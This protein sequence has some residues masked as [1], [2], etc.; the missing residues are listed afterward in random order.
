MVAQKSVVGSPYRI[1]V[2]TR[3]IEG[4]ALAPLQRIGCSRYE[5]QPFDDEALR[6]FAENWFVD[7]A[8]RADRFV[9]QIREA[10]LDELVQVPLLATIAAII[11]QQH[12]DRPLPGN[13]YQLY[14][15]YLAFLLPAR[16][17]VSG[18]FEERR[19][20]LLEHLGRVRLETDTSLVGL[21]WVVDLLCDDFVVTPEEMQVVRP[22]VEAF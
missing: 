17:S 3:P 11:F 16:T 22:R 5:L 13:Q 10:H 12:Q 8:A 9:Q 21:C 7:D 19:T 6:R 4:A 14:E 20:E 1:V 2:T 15:A 18:P